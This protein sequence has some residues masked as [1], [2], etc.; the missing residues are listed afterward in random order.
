MIHR[1]VSNIRNRFRDISIQRKVM[2]IM[3]LQS[4]IVLTLV[5]LAVIAN[6]AIV[7][8]KEVKE[9]IASLTD[10]IALNASSALVFDDRKA[11]QETLSG[12][13]EKKQVISAYIFDSKDTI[14]AQYR[15][16]RVGNYVE[17][18]ALL[19][20]ATVKAGGFVWDDDIEIV[21]NIVVDGQTIG[22]VLIQSDLSLLYSQL[23]HFIIIITTVFVSA[24]LLTYALSKSFQRV[25][26]SP[27]IELAQTMQQVS[28]N[29]DF[30]L[31]VEK[32]RLD[33][34]GTLIEGFNTMLAEIQKRDERIASYKESLED[35]IIKRTF[36]LTATNNE[37]ETTISD[38]HVAKKAAESANLA[39][40]QF[41][42]NMS[43][44]IRTP[45]NGIMGM[46]EVLLKSGLTERQ[47]HFAATIKNSS[48][49]LLTIINDILDFSKIEAGQLALETVP[50]NLLDMLSEL[51]EVFSE[52]AEWKEIIL[53]TEIDH[54]VPYSV[55]GDPVRLRQILINLVGNALKF[56]EQGQI[57]IKARTAELTATHVVIK[58][59]ITDTGIGICPEALPLIFD[60]F[61]QADSS[62]TR[63]FGGT[64]LGLSIVQ[65]LTELMGGSTGVESSFG[66]GSTFWFTTR[67]AR[68]SGQL[69]ETAFTLIEDDSVALTN[70]GV[71]V[72]VVEDTMVNREVC[73]EL[74]LHLGHSATVANNG[75]EA[76]ELLQNERFDVVLMD[77]QMPVMDG[78]KATQRHR[79]WES[80]QGVERLPII[81]LTGNAMEQ[82]K[83]LCLDAGMDD[84]LKKPFNLSD[85]RD[86]LAR[87]L[88]DLERTDS[89]NG[90]T[91]PT[92]PVSTHRENMLLL[93]RAPLDGIK[94]LR[95]PG[96]PD[97]LA[98]VISVYETDAPQLIIAMRNS[99]EQNN[100]E[101]LI[102]AV[103]SLKTSSAMLGA[104]FLADQCHR[105]EI[106]LRNG[107]ELQDA[108]QVI[109]RIEILCQSATILLRSE[110]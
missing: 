92:S 108:K 21:K 10:I 53:K 96:T 90:S 39:K 73:C 58:F 97:I 102:R 93:E 12:L 95:K 7:K 48:N 67:L 17:P 104:Q 36:Q 78:Y 99:L 22:R 11:A 87:W 23:S 85:L 63:R 110:I 77:C 56:T 25:I 106:T 60:R 62:T 65:Q 64:G 75:R 105:L 19:E 66:M 3:V 50:F 41:L 35:A 1:I 43:H 100:T 45:M 79:E 16:N 26:T 98:K 34:V 6:V 59:E 30:S 42:A 71:K 89:R 51:I 72:L 29:T 24:L 91:E 27:V 47:H 81:A 74:L 20:E 33:E 68:F 82:D 5:S 57:T 54:E 31:R 38:L 84:Y 28:S 83:Q 46:T 15:S 80:R 49:S 32:K 9:D 103:H 18:I 69:P 4:T 101:E 86:V 40:S 14:F 13:K 70:I 76:L 109:D 52:Q 44:E 8:H 55:E 107:E 37:L 61:A 94:E 88:P 2:S